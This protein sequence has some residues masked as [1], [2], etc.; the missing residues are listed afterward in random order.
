MSTDASASATQSIECAPSRARSGSSLFA[1]KDADTFLVCDSYGDIEGDGDGLFRNDT[2]VLSEFRLHIAGTKPTLLSA[3]R[4]KDNVFLTSH[5]VNNPLTP[6]GGQHTP[7]G[8]VHIQRAKL[9]WD[10]ILYERILC[11]NYG[12]GE[13]ILPLS[14]TYGADF[15]DM[16][17]VR[18]TAR[19][20]R[21]VMQSPEVAECHVTLR[22]QG[23]DRLL[24]TTT[25]SFSE[26]PSR[27]TANGARYLLV[28]PPATT[29]E[30]H[31]E[32]GTDAPVQ[33]SRRRF[34]HA[35]AQAR[36]A[37]RKRL[38][39]GARLKSSGHLFNEW[40][41]RSRA[42][43]ALL[44]TEL[45]T[46]PFPYAGIPWFSTPF[47]R[48]A[49]VTALQSLWLDPALAHGV[50]SYLAQTQATETSSFKDSAPGKIMHETRKGEMTT[51][52]ELPFGQYYGG[53]DT[54]PLFV[55][56]AGAYADRTGD[57]A[58]IDR[59]WPALAAALRWIEQS[60]DSNSLGL[61]AYDRGEKSGLANQGWKDSENSVYHADGQLAQGAIALVEVQGYAF[62]ALQAMAELADR[63]GDGAAAVRWR[64]R[65]ETLRRL[66]EERFW[67]EEA[68]FYG[69]AI[70]GS[71][72]LCRVLT[73]NPGHLLFVG[74][75]RPD[76][77][78]HVIGHLLSAA[79]DSGWGI[80]TVAV[81]QAR[82]NPMSYHNGSVWPHDTA[83]CVAGLARYGARD[84][85]VRL[86]GEM[87]E[88]AVNFDMQ[89]PE[90]FCGFARAA[91][92]PPIGYP[93][94]C[95]PQAWAAGAPFQMLQACLGIRIDGWKKELHIDRPRLPIGIDRLAISDLS[96]GECRVH[97]NFER[98]GKQVVVSPVAAG[99]G[100]VETIIHA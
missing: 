69:I 95:M 50:L 22:Y 71:G 45:A 4:S 82:F 8:V 52:G 12:D 64:S 44:T 90:L 93:V 6:L 98:L 27:L 65:A 14:F 41:E 48:D 15:A 1:L 73:S 10:G 40:I 57:M 23:L 58:L 30:L 24:R 19:Q 20:S 29:K 17:E 68:G 62:K 75:P 5:M 76:R 54:T 96:I 79:F 78:E 2:R 42:D 38:R 80:R 25:I 49:I 35:A 53:I 91:G 61:L 39:R 63:R 46:G 59:L 84:S 37:M 18:G 47:G 100:A 28:L 9:V 56:L 51:L 92:E 33:P 60:I 88:A 67:L 3:A 31:L 81:G 74:L 89:L 13:A 99:P 70:D 16:F 85:V 43:I 86:F 7:G 11:V 94:A 66:V 83:L 77:A 26:P 21:G 97:L 72:V 36:R 55:M 34:R 87:F 32:V